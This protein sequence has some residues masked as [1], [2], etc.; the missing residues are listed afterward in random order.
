M[1]KLL[2]VDDVAEALQ[3]APRTAYTFMHQMV[4]LTKPLRV[5]ENSLRVWIAERTID[6][7]EAR[8]PRISAKRKPNPEGYRIPRRTAR[9]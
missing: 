2:T 4:H 9:G 6:P 3:V 8:R 5:S 7:S 1:E